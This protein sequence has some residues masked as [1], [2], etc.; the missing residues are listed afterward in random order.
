MKTITLDI[1]LNYRIRVPKENKY[2]TRSMF[3]LHGYGSNMD[4]IFGLS[5]FFAND[6]ACISLQAPF[7]TQFGGWAWSEI[8]FNNLE[9]LPKPEQIL[10]SQKLVITSILTTIKNLQLNQKKVHLTG[11]SQGAALALSCGLIYPDL[12]NGIA[13]LSGFLRYENIK[14]EV[15]NNNIKNLNV[16]MANGTIDEVIPIQLGRKT[17]KML[18]QIGLK[19]LTYK[20]FAAGHTITSN[21]LNDILSW[22]NLIQ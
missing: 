11:F 5:Q 9:K 19:N 16:Y 3:F 18:A 6:W 17:K 7:S 15:K 22:I 8:D 12:F 4:D 13:A 14:S 20:E 10:K 1:P 2:N 21:C